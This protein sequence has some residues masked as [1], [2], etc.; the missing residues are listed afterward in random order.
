ML[1]RCTQGPGA[2]ASRG[3]EDGSLTYL[4]ASSLYGKLPK[5]GSAPSVSVVANPQVHNLAHNRHLRTICST[6]KEPATPSL[7]MIPS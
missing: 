2:A 6:P 3:M 5:A 4:S 1:P 7:S